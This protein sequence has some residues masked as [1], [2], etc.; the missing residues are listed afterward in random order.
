MNLDTRGPAP[1]R[2]GIAQYEDTGSWDEVDDAG[3]MLPEG[4]QELHTAGL[5]Y[6]DGPRGHLYQELVKRYRK[7]RVAP[8]MVHT[9][10][11]VYEDPAPD[12]MWTL[13]RDILEHTSHEPDLGRSLVERAL[14]WCEAGDPEAR[15]KRLR[16]EP[17][18]PSRGPVLDAVY[19][20]TMIEFLEAAWKDASYLAKR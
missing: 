6:G 12:W 8:R 2:D 7:P 3:N 19:V 1:W 14:L 16:D 9:D 20:R 18:V 15:S 11:K 4:M 10:L 17:T 5:T 13:A